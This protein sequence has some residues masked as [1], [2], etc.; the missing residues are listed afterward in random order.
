MPPSGTAV[1][2]DACVPAGAG[3]GPTRAAAARAIGLGRRARAPGATFPG[4]AKAGAAGPKTL[5][6]VR[7]A[8]P[9][10][11]DSR[12]RVAAA[13]EPAAVGGAAGS[14]A[15][16]D[17]GTDAGSDA[18]ADPG[19]GAGV[20]PGSDAG[21]E[22]AGDAIDGPGAGPAATAPTPGEPVVVALRC[23]ATGDADACT[24]VVGDAVLPMGAAIEGIAGIAGVEAVDSATT[25]E[26]DS[27]IGVVA[28]AAAACADGQGHAAS[29]PSRRP[30]R[31]RR[32]RVGQGPAAG[33]ASSASPRRRRASSGCASAPWRAR[34]S[35]T[36]RSR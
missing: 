14:D 23:T 28:G 7:G 11:P 12:A 6:P 30:G 32:R 16:T 9:T 35:G 33:C 2:H 8:G 24:V 26:G 13:G 3:I 5:A 27:A 29:C 19:V 17:A 1:G 4:C 31:P 22:R 15:G 20:D 36:W 10:V 25:G 21:A 18:L 34:L